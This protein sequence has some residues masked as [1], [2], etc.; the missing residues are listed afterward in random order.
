MKNLGKTTRCH[1][2]LINLLLSPELIL[3]IFGHEGAEAHEG[4]DD[5]DGGEEVPHVELVRQQPH[6]RRLEVGPQRAVL[7]RQVL[8]LCRLLIGRWE[9]W[10]H[11]LIGQIKKH[12]EK[13][14]L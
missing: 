3:D 1:I 9:G 8:H 2:P 11:S 7:F 14:T 4:E 6:Q 5:E 12:K 13:G 10:R